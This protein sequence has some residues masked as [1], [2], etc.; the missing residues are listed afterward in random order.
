MTGIKAPIFFAVVAALLLVFMPVAASAHGGLSMDEDICRLRLG[1]YAMHFSGYQPSLSGSKEF[2]ED[3]PKTGQVIVSM[4]MIDDALRNLP[5]SVR[6]VRDTGNESQLEQ[7]T[8]LFLE[9]KIYPNG[10]VSF[11]HNFE[12]SGKFVGLV[13]AGTD[14]EYVSRFPFS[15]GNPRPPYGVFALILLVIGAGYA[16]Y[17]YSGRNPQAA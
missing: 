17:K 7:D 14:G 1:V 15:V 9:P 8:V 3:I 2:C 11:E 12:N 13:T 5:I 6:I 4:D 16:F 10:S